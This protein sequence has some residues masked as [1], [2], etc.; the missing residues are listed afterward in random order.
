MEGLVAKRMVQIREVFQEIESWASEK[1]DFNQI[2]SHLHSYD[3]EFKS[4]TYEATSMVLAERDLTN[5][6]LKTWKSFAYQHGL[7]HSTQ[8]HI[9]LGWALAKT[10]TVFSS[11]ESILDDYGK[12]RV[13]DGAGYYNGVFRGRRA[14]R[15]RELPTDIDGFALES[16]VQG[17]GRSMWYI[18]KGDVTK[19]LEMISSFDDQHQ[20]ALYRGLGVACAYVGGLS[21]PE[22]KVLKKQCTHLPQFQTGVLLATKSRMEAGLM[23]LFTANACSSICGMD[24]DD[25]RMITEEATV[26]LEGEENPFPRYIAGIDAFFQSM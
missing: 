13:L 14:I 15:N 12:Y 26:K 21:V 1:D 11:I 20:P 24:M 8:I 16:Y 6:G 23:N 19:T 3:G 5:G 2:V 9:G 22:L 17:L 10:N 18:S 25:V 7:D 4:I